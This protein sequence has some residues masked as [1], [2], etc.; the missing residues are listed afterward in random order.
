MNEQA[1]SNRPG[2][3]TKAESVLKHG[4]HTHTVNACS[5]FL[6]IVP[7]SHLLIEA[8]QRKNPWYGSNTHYSILWMYL[9]HSPV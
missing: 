9:T 7:P 4:A 8:F 3:G 5:N 1:C 2:Q 6:G